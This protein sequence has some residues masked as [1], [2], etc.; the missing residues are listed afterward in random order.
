MIADV[1]G[2]G[3]APARGAG[4]EG[5]VRYR[6]GRNDNDRKCFELLAKQSARLV[7]TLNVSD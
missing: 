4:G 5:V 1:L 3:L 7:K 6:L 2:E